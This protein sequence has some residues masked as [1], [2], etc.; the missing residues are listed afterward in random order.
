MKKYKFKLCK[1]K[2]KKDAF[3]KAPDY[4]SVVELNNKPYTVIGYTDALSGNLS[5]TIEEITTERIE[6]NPF[7]KT[8]YVKYLESKKQQDM[9]NNNI[10]QN[11]E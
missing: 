9:F 4:E 3:D 1:N 2:S 11:N 5:I 7:V 6:S 8:K 10:N